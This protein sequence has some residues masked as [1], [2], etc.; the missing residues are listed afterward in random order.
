MALV[1]KRGIM[2]EGSVLFGELPQTVVWDDLTNHLTAS[3]YDSRPSPSWPLRFWRAAEG[4][5]F[6]VDVPRFVAA[7]VDC[8]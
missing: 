5:H 2:S 8:P 6:E 1:H 7:S 3:P 4:L